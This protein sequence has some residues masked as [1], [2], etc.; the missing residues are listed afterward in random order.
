MA[1]EGDLRSPPR[2]PCRSPALSAAGR[3]ERDACLELPGTQLAVPQALCVFQTVAHLSA[4]QPS[5]PSPRF[6][7][8]GLTPWAEEP[9]KGRRL[10]DPSLRRTTESL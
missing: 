4:R 10:L 8:G 5:L 7:R 3:A 6:L 9:A 1:N 2:P